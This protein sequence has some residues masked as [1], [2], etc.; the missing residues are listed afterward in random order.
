MQ[1]T[2]WLTWLSVLTLLPSTACIVRIVEDGDDEV[3]ETADSSDAISESTDSTGESSDSGDAT[4]SS[5]DSGDTTDSST[6]STDTETTDTGNEQCPPGPESPATF[7][8]QLEIPGTDSWDADITWTCSLLDFD[9]LDGLTLSLD[10]P[11]AV[12][13]VTIAVLADP[14]LNPPLLAGALISLRY[15]SEGPWWFNSYL[16][17]DM[18]GGHLFTIIDGDSLVP[19]EPYVFELPFPISTVSGICEP[20]PDG[21]GDRER[22]GLAFE[23]AGEAIVMFD[24]EYAIVGGDPGTDV[25]VAEAGHLHDILCSDTPDEWFRVLIANTGWE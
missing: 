11:E 4:D 17:L 24:P 2:R 25:W 14:Q 21:C 6:D 10:C 9:T 16:R 13:P 3:G 8:Y 22:L 15:V 1:R 5:T 7:S 12:G 20:T 18:N 19:E 23:L